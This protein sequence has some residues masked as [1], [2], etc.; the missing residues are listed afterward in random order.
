MNMIV[1]RLLQV[2]ILLLVN[3]TFTNIFH[4]APRSMTEHRIRYMCA[5]NQFARLFLASAILSS[6]SLIGPAAIAKEP[7]RI[8]VDYARVM[9]IAEPAATVI[10]GN[11]A[12]ADATVKNRQ[13]LVITG[14]SF[15]TTNLIILNE[16]GETIANEIISVGA[17]SDL[18]VTIYRGAKR[19]TLNCDPVCQPAPSAGDDSELF[20]T[21]IAQFGERSKLAEEQLQAQESTAQ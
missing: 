7:L 2:S 19:Q 18:A 1:N 13:M 16:A 17:A 14:K 9:R 15:G 12:I 6:F 8:K 21:T 5:V 10:I 20:S 3:R 11:P 4:P